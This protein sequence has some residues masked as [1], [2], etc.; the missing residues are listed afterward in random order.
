MLKYNHPYAP[1][2]TFKDHELAKVI[3]VIPTWVLDT[4][5]TGLDVIGCGEDEAVWVGMST[6]KDGAIPI[7]MDIDQFNRIVRPRMTGKAIVG[8]NLRFDYHALNWSEREI[9]PDWDTM[10]YTYFHSTTSKKSLDFMAEARGLNIIYTPEEL[11][12]GGIGNLPFKELGHYLAND[13][14]LTRTIYNEQRQKKQG[15]AQDFTFERVIQK[16][17]DR[18]VHLLTERLEIVEIEA[19]EQLQTL[20]AGIAGMGFDGNLNSSK[21]LGEW[22]SKTGRKLPRTN[23]GNWS[24][25]KDALSK[26]AENGDTFCQKLLEVR[27]MS[28]LISAFLEP[29]PQH[30]VTMSNG[31]H[32]LFPRINT[33]RTATG[34]LSYAEPNLQQIP[35]GRNSPIGKQI[36]RCL[37]AEGG[38]SVADYSQIELRVAAALSDEP[39]LLDAFQHQRDPHGETAAKIFKKRLADISPE[40]RHAAKAMN[41]GILFGAGPKRLATELKVPLSDAY[42]LFSDYKNGLSGL[43]AWCETTWDR[44]ERTQIAQTHLGRTRLFGAHED[45]RPGLSVVVQGTAAEM[46]R[47]ALIE[48]EEANLLPVLTV[49]D[50]IACAGKGK[51]KE[52][53]EIMQHAAENACPELAAKVSFPADPEEGPTWGE[54]KSV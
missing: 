39:V 53:S 17:E 33:T 46:L 16:I 2:V 54:L 38:L 13:V 30:A 31:D 12:R 1:F 10:C 34:R 8:H 11:K 4:E 32:I 44:M 26:L 49:H 23:S 36:R 45:T 9:Y 22:L 7:V 50:E 15:P 6:T 43:T 41:F 47:H 27:K 24:T 20:Q 52:L 48:V 19:K 5:T 28:K 21:Q 14:I 37:T 51:A 25:S 18:G 29:L 3:E 40:E 42:N 35:K